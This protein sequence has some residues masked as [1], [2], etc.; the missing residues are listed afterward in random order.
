MKLIGFG[1]SK[2]IVMFT[3]TDFEMSKAPWNQMKCTLRLR[4]NESRQF[5]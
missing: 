2:N 4:F 1:V 5:E 3:L